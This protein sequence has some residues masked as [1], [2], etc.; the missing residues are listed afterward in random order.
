MA[1][2][3]AV[4]SYWTDRWSC[5]KCSFLHLEGIA[6]LK[7][8]TVEIFPGKVSCGHGKVGCLY[9]VQ[10]I[11]RLHPSWGPRHQSALTA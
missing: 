8:I 11:T 9:R 4:P 10:E 5:L 2:L 1:D 7:G 3:A 6:N